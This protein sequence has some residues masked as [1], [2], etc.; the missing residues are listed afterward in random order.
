MPE[1]AVPATAAAVACV[2]LVSLRAFG[3]EHALDGPLMVL[4]WVP[5]L[6]AYVL[7]TRAG[8]WVGLAGVVL[9]AAALQ[10]DSPMF[11]PLFEMITV[12][13]WLAG[14]MVLSRRRLIDQLAARNADL[15]SERERYARESV[16]FERARTARELHD[17]VAHS[18]SLIVVQAGAGQRLRDS[19][20]PGLA[21]ALDCVAQAADQARTEVDSL[22][23]LMSGTPA[24]GGPA[25]LE[26]VDE[27]VRRTT[28]RASS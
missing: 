18:L 26:R 24:G 21:A 25:G 19:D 11:N 16:R 9:L 6:V 22:I 8:L 15:R 5:L 13:P 2:V 17:I 20:R 4:V 3:L 23:A 10:A 1:R 12:G 7:G 27:L 28:P 14:R